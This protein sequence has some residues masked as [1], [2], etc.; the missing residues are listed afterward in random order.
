MK[1]PARSRES[2]QRLTRDELAPASGIGRMTEVGALATA[3]SAMAIGVLN[4][5][6]F[7][8]A[9]D[10]DG[11][12]VT[13]QVED[14]AGKNALENVDQRMI[15]PDH[16]AAPAPSAEL[17]NLGNTSGQEEHASALDRILDPSA[18]TARIAE[19]I[20]SSV[21]HV[22]DMAA[23]GDRTP[24]TLSRDIVEQAQHIAQEVHGQFVAQEPLAVLA[25][26]VPPALA[27]DTLGAGIIHDVDDVLSKS[28]VM[29]LLHG[30]SALADPEKI[31]DGVVGSLHGLD[32]PVDVSALI[33]AP[34]ET[35][36]AIPEALLGGTDHGKNPL[37]DLFY[38]DGGDDI[39]KSVVGHAGEAVADLMNDVPKLGF[40]A[41]PLDLG[42]ELG[43]LTHGHGPLQLL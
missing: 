4:A 35:V 39:A 16:D 33:A 30:A 21:S 29:D 13:P 18:L 17:V 31:I 9:D 32:L 19:Q 24:Q 34:I 28:G 22:L 37:A 14:I 25:D 20:A 43:G 7:A 36:T 12:Q 15:A 3:A 1:L 27:L 38:D 10:R 5:K 11:H 41:Q 8:G 2:G 42:D 40:L 23:G 6:E 26:L